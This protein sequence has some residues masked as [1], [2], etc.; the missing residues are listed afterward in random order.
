MLAFD[1]LE[2]HWQERLLGNI[3]SGV[4]E[5]MRISI[6]KRGGTRWRTEAI[7][8]WVGGFCICTGDY[9]SLEPCEM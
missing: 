5:G 9:I 7:G 6:S 3:D 1:V 2:F 4:L 8:S